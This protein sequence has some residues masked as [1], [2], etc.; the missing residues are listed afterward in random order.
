MHGLA[1]GT[2]AFVV[3][4]IVFMIIFTT[5]AHLTTKDRRL[6]KDNAM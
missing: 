4:W 3:I 2:I 5:C 6:K 1:L